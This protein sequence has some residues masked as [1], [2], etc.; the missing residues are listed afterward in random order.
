MR[1][2]VWSSDVCASDLVP[3]VIHQ[4]CRRMSAL[5]DVLEEFLAQLG[6]GVLHL[7]GEDALLVGQ[8]AAGAPEVTLDRAGLRQ[9]LRVGGLHPDGWGQ[10]PGGRAIGRA[11]CRDGVGRSR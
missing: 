5:D 4:E 1:I 10:Y 7:S 11:S 6:A 8:L 2:S 3:E 9:D